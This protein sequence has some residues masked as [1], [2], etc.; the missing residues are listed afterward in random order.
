M[1]V[2]ANDVAVLVPFVVGTSRSHAYSPY[3]P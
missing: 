3:L 1:I 2:I